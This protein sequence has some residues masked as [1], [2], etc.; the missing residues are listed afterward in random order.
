[1]KIDVHVHSRHSKRPSQWILKRIGCPESFTDPLQLYQIAKSRGM[2][3]VTLSDHNTID[4]AL[5]IAHLPGTFISEEITTYFPD[6]GCKVHVLALNINEAHHLEL[7]KL[8]RNIFDLAR[9]LK[10]ENI[11]AI[12]AHPLY[13]INDRLT[14]AHF[15][16]MLL[17]FQHFELNG[18]RN[19]RE[20][21]VLRGIIARLSD[22][23]INQLAD[24]HDLAPVY[25]RPWE[26]RLWGGSDDHSALNIARTFTEINGI[27]DPRRLTGDTDHLQLTVHGRSATPLTM[28]HNLYSIAYQY[29][30]SKFNLSRYAEKDV[31]VRYLDRNLRVDENRQSGLLSRLYLLWRHRREKITQ[32]PVSDSLMALL[33]HETRLLIQDDPEF[34]ADKNAPFDFDLA[35][36]RWFS[37]VDR[38]SKRVMLHFGNHLIDH[39]S[40]A[41]LFD[42][43]ST[44]GSA[45]GL[46]T[47]LAPYFVSYLQFAKD[48]ELSLAAARR[49]TSAP[50]GEDEE[51]FRFA[52]FTDTYYEVNGVAKTL[53]QQVYY[54]LKNNKAYTLV[55]C[56]TD[57]S[58]DQ[59][60]VRNFTPIGTHDLPE[61]PEL[62]IF[63]PPF[64]EMLHYCYDTEIDHI[65][66]ATPGPVGLAALAIAKILKLPISGTYHTAIPQYAQ[67]LTDDN[68]MEELTWKYVLWYYD[69][70]DVIYAPSQGTRD[71]LVAKG[72]SADKIK[73]YPRGIDVDFFHPSKRNGVFKNNYDLAVRTKLLYVGRV[74]K[75][76]NLDILTRAFKRMVADG[77]KVQLVIV[78]DGPYLKEMQ[79]E[80]NG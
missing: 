58:T 11:L 19:N 51:T 47:L 6:V 69:Q 25:P 32:T 10:D 60:G 59:P 43:F 62:K 26:K 33:R 2:S 4:G 36:R 79:A 29:Y 15:E 46:Y 30:C 3:H 5:E 18:A 20:N 73:R 55:T 8:R 41:K 72:I 56:R 24:A 44:L 42:I 12:V 66:T 39:L 54:A 50:A 48:R 22:K 27:R 14:M 75:E 23:T 68:A 61:Y 53:Q 35:E 17:L 16:Q 1:M 13:A 65:H 7:Q 45:G 9:Y 34:Y 21:V 78:G 49:F 64:L 67:V 71:E 80:M 37:F 40:G 28:A 38:A 70:L 52:H 31:L 77:E 63:Y 76:K 74:S 57:E